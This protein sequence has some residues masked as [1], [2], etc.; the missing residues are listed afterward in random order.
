MITQ[1]ISRWRA[2]LTAF[3]ILAELAH[4]AWEH[5][6]GGV[7]SHHILNSSDLPAISNWWGLLA[8]PV[9]TWILTGRVQ[10]RV[11]LQS[12]GS[13]DAVTLPKQVIAGLL[14][15]LLFGILLSVAFTNNYETIAATLFLG[16]FGL[17]LLLP[18]YRAECVLGFVLGMTFTFGVVIPLVIGSV[19]AAISAVAQLYVRP[20]LGR[21]RKRF[22]RAESLSE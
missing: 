3:V 20:L 16:M 8:L 17:A 5:F 14:G 22:R 11:A 12:A 21:L 18:V 10:R 9:L 19:L 1:H 4:L 6:N 2:G 13:A 15:A 7:L